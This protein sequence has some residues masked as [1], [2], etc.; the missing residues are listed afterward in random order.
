MDSYVDLRFNLV[1]NQHGS[2]AIDYTMIPKITEEDIIAGIDNR[3]D[4]QEIICTECG[5]VFPAFVRFDDNGELEI[6]CDSEKIIG[7]K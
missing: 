6:F 5:A 1:N 2:L 3:S 4:T 7:R